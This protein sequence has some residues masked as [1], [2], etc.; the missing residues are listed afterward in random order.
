M[1]KKILT[2]GICFVIAVGL[3]AQVAI[4]EKGGIPG[5]PGKGKPACNDG[6]DNDLDNLTDMDDPGCESK[7]DRDENNCGDGVCNGNE[8]C[9]NCQPDCATPIILCTWVLPD[10]EPPLM[11]DPAVFCNETVWICLITPI[12]DG[13]LY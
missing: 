3:I 4:A 1:D 7:K 6:V 2:L 5:K 13:I 12:Y 11:C 8:D 10:C 9:S